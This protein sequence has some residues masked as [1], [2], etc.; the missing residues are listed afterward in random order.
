MK[1]KAQITI[2]ILVGVIAIILL[3]LFLLR[4]AD[5]KES[6]L[7]SV[8]NEEKSFARISENFKKYFEQCSSEA[9]L[10]ANQE[11]GLS[12][13]NKAEYESYA[14]KYVEDCLN[15]IFNELSEYDIKKGRASAGLNINDFSIIA[16]IKYP[17]EIRDNEK[18]YSFDEYTETFPRIR[19]IHLDNGIAK[20]DTVLISPDKKA[21][22][23][24]PK[25]VKVTDE[26]GNPVE[27][28]SLKIEDKHFGGLENS[29]VVGNIVYNGLPDG[30]RFSEP[31]EL[32]ID[33]RE[34]DLPAFASKER[35]AI[36]YY[37]KSIWKGIRTEVSGNTAKA[38]IRHFTI[39]GMV[40]ECQM[41]E[42]ESV[43]I[44][45]KPKMFEQK[46]SIL[47]KKDGDSEATISNKLRNEID[48]ADKTDK[49]DETKGDKFCGLDK[50]VWEKENTGAI[51]PTLSYLMN[52]YSKGEGIKDWVNYIVKTPIE[53][54]DVNVVYGSDSDSCEKDIELDTVCCCVNNGIDEKDGKNKYKCYD[55]EMTKQECAQKLVEDGLVNNEFN[56]NTVF[57][58]LTTDKA[59]GYTTELYSDLTDENTKKEGLSCGNLNYDKKSQKDIEEDIVG[60]KSQKC[61]LGKTLPSEGK[62]AIYSIKF[63]KDSCVMDTEDTDKKDEPS[64]EQT[65]DSIGTCGFELEEKTSEKEYSIDITY[66]EATD[67]PKNEPMCAMCKAQVVLEGMNADLK[68]LNNEELEV[69]IPCSE[70]SE[71][72][73]IFYMD[74]EPGCYECKDGFYKKSDK[75]CDITNGCGDCLNLKEGGNCPKSMYGDYICYTKPTLFCEQGTFRVL[76]DEEDQNKCEPCRKDPSKKDCIEI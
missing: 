9:I 49:A 42:G 28:I 5:R 47:S 29:I 37:D 58:A 22:I 75:I 25:G 56:I 3:S 33:L 51:T 69:K 73:D 8:S 53:L 46:Y 41:P 32:S 60:Y 43:I 40:Q 4:L 57:I 70:G 6:N 52:Y 64:I 48:E 68:D 65:D 50:G 14:A 7:A 23:F 17:V 66:A 2:F 36:A 30:A 31:V 38:K 24:I 18:R 76:S 21:S 10:K 27:D 13:K 59:E 45:I 19:S 15:P 35:L 44:K 12:E 63:P 67:A 16:E 62:S 20:K 74:G 71:K 11:Y 39:F 55:K 72:Y 54:K 34:K 61:V 1:T 26:K